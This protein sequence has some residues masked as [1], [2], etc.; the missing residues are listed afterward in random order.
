M[1]LSQI[2]HEFFHIPDK[3]LSYSNLSKEEWQAI[4]SLAEDRS[5][6]IKKVEKRLCVVVWDFKFLNGQIITD[7]HIKVTDR[8]QYLHYT[9]SYPHHTKRSIV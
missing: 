7:I 1:F 5:I 8:H 6:V 9:S 2:Q 4:R 3:C